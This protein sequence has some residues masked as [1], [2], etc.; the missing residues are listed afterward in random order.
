MTSNKY[1]VHPGTGTVLRADECVTVN[2]P[3]DILALL[4][5]DDYFDDTA[6]VEYATR[7]RDDNPTETRGDDLHLCLFC[8]SDEISGNAWE[9]DGPTVSQVVDCMS[10][11]ETWV[12]SFQYVGSDRIGGTE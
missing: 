11:G 5:G 1:V 6:I 3:N 2:V 9:Q 4:T 8:G 12:E 7:Y 10:C